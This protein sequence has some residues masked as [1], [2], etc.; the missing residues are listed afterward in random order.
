MES[1]HSLPIIEVQPR[2][3]KGSS[4]VRS[5]RNQGLVPSVIY[6]R[7][8]E[9]LDASVSYKDFARVAAQS[10]SSQVFLLKSQDKRFDGRTC[11]VKEVQKDYLKNKVLHVDF[12]SLKDDEEI[13]VRV[14]IH[15]KG[16]A[17]GVKNEGGILTIAI[18]DLGVTCLPRQI[19]KEV[20]LDVSE[21]RL[22]KSI[23]A[24]DVVL[25]E[26]VALDDDP[27][28]TLVSVVAVRLVEETPATAAVGEEA[29][30]AA[31]GAEA[32]AAGGDA[33]AAPAGED[34][35]K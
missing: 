19:P 30:D 15:I 32:A 13:T 7:G 24:S 28:E 23:H 11:I 1:S 4:S 14:P 22:G 5:L 26:G 31:A 29:A 25:P 6:Q 27:Q 33:K 8:E 18:H 3:V 34:K 12:Q 17:Y 35:K 21:L 2:L 9:S 20:V 16:E 10:T